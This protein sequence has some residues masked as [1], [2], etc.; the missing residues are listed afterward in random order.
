M[1]KIKIR[2]GD[3]VVVIAGGDRGRRGEV[4]R[5]VKDKGRVV[6]KGVNLVERRRKPTQA[7]PQGTS[8]EREAAIDLS[9]VM[10]WDDKANK[11]T[12]I[13]RKVKDG[14][15]VRFAKASGTELK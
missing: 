9:N 1:T 6:V 4:L 14:A 5:L 3:T 8:V 11:P 15:V 2:K 13:G 10:L 7:N 12:R